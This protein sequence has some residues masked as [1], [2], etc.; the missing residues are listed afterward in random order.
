MP[1]EN[2]PFRV[3]SLQQTRNANRRFSQAR[4]LLDAHTRPGV[5]VDLTWEGLVKLAEKLTGMGISNH[6]YL[7]LHKVHIDAFKS[8]IVAAALADY[9]KTAY[10]GALRRADDVAREVGS[11]LARCGR[12]AERYKEMR[13][14]WRRLLLEALAT[15]DLLDRA[16]RDPR[17]ADNVLA[18][19]IGLLTLSERTARE[20]EE[21]IGVLLF[22]R[23]VIAGAHAEVNRLLDASR[24]FLAEL[25]RQP[26]RAIG[27]FARANEQV[28]QLG[29]SDG[30]TNEE[31]LRPLAELAETT[32]SLIDLWI[33]ERDQF[34]LE[35]QGIDV[36]RALR[37]KQP[38]PRAPVR[39]STR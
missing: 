39:R 29:E 38:G 35:L 20:H 5:L 33:N 12:G 28:R 27:A 34:S 23:L 25:Q 10:D 19:I 8:A 7:R 36:L 1:I 30:R 26:I 4:K 15:R 37:N 18:R 22:Q 6:P 32:E 24:Q 9:S 3:S 21:I 13:E 14:S 31:V 11:L 17:R 16:V 2:L